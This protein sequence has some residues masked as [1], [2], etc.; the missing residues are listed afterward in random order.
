MRQRDR[1][2][3]NPAIPNDLVSVLLHT[4]P[5]ACF[6]HQGK[7]GKKSPATIH[8]SLRRR[9]GYDGLTRDTSSSA[10]G[11]KPCMTW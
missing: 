4:P 7:S 10:G 9:R 3:P 8:W 1:Y 6:S 11:N 5:G 2:W